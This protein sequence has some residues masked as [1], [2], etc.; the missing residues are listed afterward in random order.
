MNVMTSFSQETTDESDENNI[1]FQSI[2]V[3]FQ[4]TYMK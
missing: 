4:F 1:T 2:V 3:I